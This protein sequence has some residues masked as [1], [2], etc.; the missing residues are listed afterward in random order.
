MCALTCSHVVTIVDSLKGGLRPVSEVYLKLNKRDGSSTLVPAKVVY[1]D[2]SLDFAVLALTPSRHRKELQQVYWKFI[3]PSGWLS[4]SSLREGDP[5][6]CLGYPLGL[7][8]GSENHPLL[9]TGI[10]AQLVSGSPSFLIDGF[11]QPGHSGGPVF[12]MSWAY[13]EC[14]IRLIGVITSFPNEY[15]KVLEEVDLVPIRD[16]KVVLNP[17]FSYVLAMDEII[18]ILTSKV[19]FKWSE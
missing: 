4:T 2:R 1:S 13:D 19:G 18:P 15:G 12:R 14:G 6:M 10:I 11:V 3:P 17:G 7:G 5:V 16:R 8:I 9:R